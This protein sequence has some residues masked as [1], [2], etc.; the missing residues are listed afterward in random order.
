MTNAASIPIAWRRNSR[1][2]RISLRLDP[3]SDTIIITLPPRATQ[4]SGLAWLHQNTAWIASALEARTIPPILANGETIPLNGT[5]HTIQH[6]P[7]ARRGVWIEDTT[8]HISGDAAFL[9]RRLLDF[10]RKQA[11]A[12]F[13]PTITRHAENMGLTPRKLALRDTRSRWGSC[14]RDG[15]IML[16]WRLVMAPP[17]VQ[18]YVIIHELA[19]LRHF[20]HSPDFWNFVDR[21]TPHRHAAETW[22]KQNGAALQ[23]LA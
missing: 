7:D 5:S 10:L 16:N 17:T 22:L 3:R 19:H 21:H 11:A 1:A 18:D 12:S 2:R 15:R 6:R 13:A 23:R 4:A 8:I 14:T 9:P 20:N